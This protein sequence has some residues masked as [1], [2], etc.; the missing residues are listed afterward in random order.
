MADITASA[1]KALANKA[2]GKLLIIYFDNDQYWYFDQEND[3]IT[4]DMFETIGGI[5]FIKRKSYISSNSRSARTINAETNKVERSGI[6]ISKK[7]IP[8]WNY[9]PIDDIQGFLLLESEKDLPYIDKSSL[10]SIQ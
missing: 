8:V 10:F 5:E 7:D 1:V 2:G 6:G 3:K 4:D 9:K